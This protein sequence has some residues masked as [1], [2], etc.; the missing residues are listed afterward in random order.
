M[1]DTRT[2]S[3]YPTGNS[4]PVI[5]MLP[6]DALDPSPYQARIAY[7]EEDLRSLAASIQKDGV[8]EPILVR[9][10]QNRYQLVAG[11]GRVQACKL[12]GKLEIP[13]IVGDYSDEDAARIGLVENLRRRDLNPVEKAR[14]IKALMDRCHLTQEEAAKELNTTRDTVAQ[15][16]R[17][18]T[19]PPELQELVSRDTISQSH[20]EELA[21][22]ADHPTVLKEAI[23]VVVKGQLNRAET[24][25]IVK[26]RLERLELQ[27]E[28][29]SYVHSEEF[30]IDLAYL[31]S[32]TPKG[33]KLIFCPSCSSEDLEGDMLKSCKRCGWNEE[34]T[35]H[36]VD[37]L[38]GK[39][40]A[41][42]LKRL[43]IKK[44]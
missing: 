13:A 23:D 25:E 5:Q 19:F 39:V 7:P 16:L 18:L 29:S 35:W 42:L 27:S 8:L 30:I 33:E 44:Q 1:T 11:W 36:R 40:S 6:L 43:G 20:A 24:I 21:R 4:K 28:I 9:K 12:A 2:E 3:N 26:E 37:R 34:K 10:V 38:Q 15:S 31:L 41:G 14:G 17:L 22:L 32:D